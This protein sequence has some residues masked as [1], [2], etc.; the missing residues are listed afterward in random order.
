[1]D[2][3]IHRK[4]NIWKRNMKKLNDKIFLH[5]IS[6]INWNS[7]LQTNKNNVNRSFDNFYTEINFL[8]R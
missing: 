8:T 1:M 3:G 2:H 5:D 7:K 4:H 6:Q